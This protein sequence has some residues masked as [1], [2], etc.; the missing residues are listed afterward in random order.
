MRL[1]HDHR[2]APGGDS[3]APLCRLR[4]LGLAGRV[5]RI[6]AGDGQEAPHH[7][8]ELLQRGDNDHRPIHQGARQLLRIL[9]DSLHHALGVLDL[10]DGVL[11]LPVEHAA[12]GDDHHAVIDLRVG[13]V[14][15]A[16][17]AV[18]EPRDTVG[19]AATGRVLDEIVAPRSVRRG[20]CDQ[21]AHGVQLVIAREDQRLALHGARALIVLDLLV[22]ALDEHIRAENVQKPLAFKHFSPE[23]AGAVARRV[24]RVASAAADIAGPAAP[25][26]RKEARLFLRQARRHMDLVGVGGEVDQ[27]ALAELEDGSVGVAVL[28]VLPHGAAPGL[29]RHRIL[30]L[31]GGYRQAVE[32]EDQVHGCAAAGV[33]RDLPR[34]R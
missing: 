7:E 6:G 3:L 27:G 8:G 9:V 28:L 5:R 12:V 19:L 34:D 4:T 17:E 18:R 13:V 26:E 23:V 29:A 16:G 33:T 25:V 11:K 32:R 31:A 24:R 22:A 21:A 30:E 20:G 10:V 14:V 1:V 15:Q 2:V